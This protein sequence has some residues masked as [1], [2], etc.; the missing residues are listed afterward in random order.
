MSTGQ[1]AVTVLCGWEGN[2]RSSVS[3]LCYVH[4]WAQWPKKISEC[5]AYTSLWSIM[6]FTFTLYTQYNAV[7]TKYC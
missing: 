6:C 5:L 7:V 1:G 4:L 2:H 3:R